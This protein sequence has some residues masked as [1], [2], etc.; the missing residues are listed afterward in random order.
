[1]KADCSPILDDIEEKDKGIR[2]KDKFKIGSIK[3]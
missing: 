2:I 3:G 1:L